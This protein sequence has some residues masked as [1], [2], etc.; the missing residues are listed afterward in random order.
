MQLLKGEKNIEYW[1][2]HHT[3][4]KFVTPPSL[5]QRKETPSFLEPLEGGCFAFCCSDLEPSVLSPPFSWTGFG[6]SSSMAASWRSRRPTHT[7]KWSNARA[8]G[9][10]CIVCC[11]E[12]ANQQPHW[13]QKQNNDQQPHWIQKHNNDPLEIDKLCGKTP[14]T[15]N[16]AKI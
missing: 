8:R 11:K 3:C 13:I 9:S 16:T 12:C 15:R 10:D 6:A 4:V 14:N 1:K 5:P 2:I 7:A